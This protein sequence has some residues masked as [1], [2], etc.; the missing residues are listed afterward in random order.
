MY[1]KLAFSVAAHLDSEIMI[2]DEVLAVGDMT[3]Q[4]K[5]INK[6]REVAD[7]GKTIL[8]VSHNM[9]TVRSL[10]DR[11]MVLNHG[12]IQY[13][14]NVNTAIGIYLNAGDNADKIFYGSEDLLRGNHCTLEH[15]L[16]S[17]EILERETNCVYYGDVLKIRIGWDS[18]TLGRDLQLKVF[19]TNTARGIVGG[20]FLGKLEYVVG[21]NYTDVALDT[22]Y[23]YPGTY[24]PNFK[25]YTQ[26]A[27]GNVI[28]YDTCEALVFTVEHGEKSLHLREWYSNWGSVVLPCLTH[29]EDY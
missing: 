6:M 4:N 19:F 12:K 17:V 11:C 10:C 1:V 3:F 9:A 8:Y 14:G 2:M 13:D 27:D 21:R 15:K 29:A 16:H 22:S 28:T 7:S 20:S 26:D 24:I 23:F 25:L 18:Q 5:C